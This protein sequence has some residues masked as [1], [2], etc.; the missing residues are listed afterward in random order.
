MALTK[1]IG[2]GLAT[3]GLPAGSVLQIIYASTTVEVASSSA[4][5]ADTGL[6]AAITPSATSSKI[7]IIYAV[8]HFMTANTAN[9]HLK[10]VRDSTDLVTHGNVGYAGSSTVMSASSFQHLDSP[11][12]TSAITYKIQFNRINAGTVN[13]QYDDA[14]GDGFST[15]VLMEIAG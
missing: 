6:T 13:V 4:T 14:G 5:F 2:D 1:V 15:M 8:E 7:L 12:S 10:V 9:G 11:S 3:S